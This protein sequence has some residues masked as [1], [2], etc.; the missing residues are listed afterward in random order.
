M[1]MELYIMEPGKYELNKSVDLER[2][3]QWK[4]SYVGKAEQLEIPY[5]EL[6]EENIL[7]FSVN[8]SID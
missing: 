3:N 8:G 6:T 5:Q 7:K 4:S 2:Y 1:V